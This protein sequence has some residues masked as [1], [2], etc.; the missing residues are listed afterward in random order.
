MTDLTPY[1]EDDHIRVFLAE[2][3]RLNRKARQILEI[4]KDGDWHTNIE[5]SK[6]TIRY[7]AR[8]YELRKAGLRIDK[9]YLGEGVWAYRLIR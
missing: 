5:L 4:L 6:I 8:L 9:A 2:R 1:L 7:G 3:E